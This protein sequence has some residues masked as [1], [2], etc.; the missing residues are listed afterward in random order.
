MSSAKVF[1]PVADLW[2]WFDVGAYLE[3]IRAARSE[4]MRRMIEES[5]SFPY[6]T[7]EDPSVGLFQQQNRFQWDIVD[8]G[9]YPGSG[10]A[11][12]ETFDEAVE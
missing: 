5:A 6:A 10:G 2:N 7:G 1:V 9:V 11:S 3:A 8:S 12:C 4:L